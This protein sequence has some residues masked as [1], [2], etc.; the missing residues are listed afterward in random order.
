MDWE[1]EFKKF[2]FK[3]NENVRSGKL[4]ANQKTLSLPKEIMSP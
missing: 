2:G 3:I 4:E 1:F